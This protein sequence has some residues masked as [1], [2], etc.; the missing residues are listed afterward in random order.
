VREAQRSPAS[1][2]TFKRY[3]LNIW[4]RGSS[5][6][7]SAAD[8]EACRRV[9]TAAD[10][11]GREC[12][13]GLDLSRTRDMTALS[14][15]FPDDDTGGYFVLPWFWLPEA[16]LMAAESPE[17]WRVWARQ[18]LLAATP[19]VVCDYDAIL[20]KLVELA[21]V[22][23]IQELAYDPYNAERLTQDFPTPPA[24]R[25]CRSRKQCRISRRLP[26]SLSG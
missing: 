9:F 18:G 19:G 3:G 24:L 2:A 12:W 8:W 1:V 17:R 13:A 16:R 10:L 15:V 26:V 25:G 20:A 23:A 4:T 22:Y 6:A 11:A 5:P 21:D 14:L 7:L